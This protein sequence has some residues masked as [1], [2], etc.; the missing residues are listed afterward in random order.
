MTDKDGRL[1]RHVAEAADAWLRDPL[2]AGVYRRLVEA[3]LAWRSG[4]GRVVQGAGGG[5]LDR[6]GASSAAADPDARPDSWVDER[7][8]AEPD[9]RRGGPPETGHDVGRVDDDA[10]YLRPERAPRAL[11]S[12]LADVASMLRARA[13]AP[14]SGSGSDTSTEPTEPT[15]LTEPTAEGDDAP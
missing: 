12:T 8:D 15:E 10:R 14:D 6:D 4:G 3:T 9:P 13:A 7:L 11:G 1:A 5:T 2:D